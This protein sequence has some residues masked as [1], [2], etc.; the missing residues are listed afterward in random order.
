M[1]RFFVSKFKNISCS[2]FHQNIAG[3]LN[4]MHELDI[5]LS[6]L[7]ESNKDVIAV[8]LTEHFIIRGEEQFLKLNNFHL[9]SI[10]SRQMQRRGGSCILL[11]NGFQGVELLD[12]N[13]LSIEKHF[14]IC[15][16]E[17]A[18]LKLIVICIYRTPNSNI[19]LF[20]D[21]INETLT[22]LRHKKHK[23]IICG[24]FNINT[25]VN[26]S[27]SAQFLEILS[28]YGFQCHIREPTR[29]N[30]C[31]DN[32]LSNIPTAVGKTHNFC[33]SDHN[34]AQTI[35]FEI[36]PKETI[37]KHYF[38]TT[39]DL[40]KSN[41]AKFVECISSMTFSEI[42][43]ISDTNDAFNAF[44]NELILFYKLCFPLIRIRNRV[45][46]GK[47]TCVTKGL[48]MSCKTKRT[49][50]FNYY[51]NKNSINKTSY[52]K[53]SKLL[54]KCINGIQTLCNLKYI[55]NSKNKG[56]ATWDVVKRYVDNSEC[57]AS[58]F[59][60]NIVDND[61][62]VSSGSDIA[63]LFNNFF[64]DVVQNNTF[65]N[66]KSEHHTYNLKSNEFSIFLNPTTAN[67]VFNTIHSLKNS[68]S[69]GYDDI[70]S[71]LLKSIALFIAEPL[72]YIINLSLEQGCFPDK[73]KLSIIK[74]LYKKG[75]KV[76]RNNYRPI[77]LTPV[78]SKVFERIMYKRILNFLDKYDILANEQ[79]GFRK[80]KSTQ[81]ATFT[82]INRIINNINNRIP[83]SALLLD[84][85]K[86]FDYVDHSLLISKLEN[87][88]I[89]GSCLSW[90]KSYLLN[91]KQLT[92]ITK[93]DNN[94]NSVVK[95]DSELRINDFGVPQ[96]S[97]L[98]PLLFLIY[99][100]DLPR[101]LTHDCVLFADDTTIILDCKNR[102]TY[103]AEI[104]K[105]LDDVIKWL[106]AN[107]LKINIEKTKLI[108]FKTYKSKNTHLN[109][110]YKNSLIQQIQSAKF[111]GI[112][113]DTHFSWKEHINSLCKKINKF[114]FALRKVKDVTSRQTSLMVY[115][116]Y[117]C[118]I[119]RY[120]IVVWGNSSE[121]MRVFIAQKKCIRALF[122][123]EWSESCRAVFKSKNL[124]TVPSIYIYEVAKFVKYHNYLFVTNDNTHKR[125]ITN[126]PL[127]MPV[128]KL[129][130]YRK[131]CAYMVPLIFN[132][133]P[134]EI[135]DLP[136]KPFCCALRKWLIQES[137]YSTKDFLNKSSCRYGALYQSNK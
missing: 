88:G 102:N 83:T 137:Y 129:E 20:F 48:K 8:C 11:R 4:K 63:N 121:I 57:G 71:D 38:T 108:N 99:V 58:K 44:H 65:V 92:R 105:T 28:N 94:S 122:G 34:T 128:P 111:L 78:L 91:R 51:L 75:S 54:R 118:S 84:L 6:E 90:F 134:K 5:A 37:V 87:Y 98:G 16:I 130:L 100:N 114:V 22:N 59:I 136:Y 131:S 43:T 56:K 68:K 74:P 115:H 42:H 41:L 1:N 113:L 3:A 89:R 29:L 55:T 127:K 46:A 109:V 9:T 40:S 123:M 23:I 104:N 101:A 61:N 36:Q 80:C 112:T 10:Y 52:L 73:L 25:L 64:I 119:I 86:A 45:R 126:L 32:I 70:N 81:L 17:I 14:E 120:G 85:S 82:L 95:F 124:L 69:A 93:F 72:A 19:K 117:I 103:E 110:A 66:A 125:S 96:G 49:L 7:H 77:A 116:A 35:D 27:I 53:Y 60:E 13:E 12:I 133:L 39:Y 47:L 106:D 97:I 135:I 76:D 31:I 21:K 67:E 33:L 15:C 50:R 107:K 24:D 2:I 18:Q 30:K 79:F 132:C 62:L 26:D